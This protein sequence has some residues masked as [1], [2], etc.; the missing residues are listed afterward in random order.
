[1]FSFQKWSSLV[2]MTRYMERFIHLVP[3]LQKLERVMR[4]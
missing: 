2:E 4:T 3:G 1:M